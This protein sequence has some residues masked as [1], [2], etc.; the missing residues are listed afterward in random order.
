[1]RPS[2]EPQGWGRDQILVEERRTVGL[3][4]LIF[5]S[6]VKVMFLLRTGAL[7]SL[8]A[9]RL[10]F[11]GLSGLSQ[12]AVIVVCAAIS[13]GVYLVL[14]SFRNSRLPTQVVVAILCTVGFV[15]ALSVYGAAMSRIGI[16][17]TELDFAS[18]IRDTAIHGWAPFA[19]YSAAILALVKSN[20]ARRREREAAALERAVQEA[21]LRAM[22]YQVDPHL[23]FNALNSISAMVLDGR[24]D[25]AEDMLLRLA[26]YFRDSLTVEPTDDIPLE[27]ELQVQSQYL[28]IERVRFGDALRV[29]VDVP[30]SLLRALVPGFILQPIIENAVK[31]GGCN[32]QEEPLA[33][34]ITARAVDEKLSIQ[35]ENRGK[36]TT[37]TGFASTGTG[38]RNVRERLELRFGTRQS[39]SAE[40][41]GT[42]GFRVRLSLP[43]RMA[44]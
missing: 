2:R 34:Q 13:Y 31:H 4:I 1:M 17:R 10:A 7:T 9:L 29:Q 16:T 32:N 22:R 35:I 8:D 40:Q 30:D 39:L 23:L 25:E 24:N 44:A 14:S 15:L 36:L 20:E 38:L 27:L 21:R 28:E 5:W 18:R 11:A 12:V 26:K 3:L 42:E 37:Q 41:I 6:V 33:L 19:L 43:L